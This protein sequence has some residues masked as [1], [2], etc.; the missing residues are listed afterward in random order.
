MLILSSPGGVSD[1][2]AI[3]VL[4]NQELDAMLDSSQSFQGEYCPVNLGILELLCSVMMIMILKYCQ[5]E[6]IPFQRS[7]L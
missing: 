3:L 1:W 7:P 6:V 4:Q 2:V 5:W